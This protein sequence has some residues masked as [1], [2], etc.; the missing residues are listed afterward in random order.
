MLAATS[1]QDPLPKA[2]VP[3]AGSDGTLG[4]NIAAP[5]IHQH[6][7]PLLSGLQPSAQPLAGVTNQPVRYEAAGGDNPQT[8][9]QS[10]VKS[11]PCDTDYSQ[12]SM[13]AEQF[14]TWR[15]AQVYFGLRQWLDR[16]TGMHGHT[17][18]LYT[19]VH[20]FQRQMGKAAGMGEETLF[21]FPL[22]SI[23]YGVIIL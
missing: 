8:A 19:P 4:A 18:R 3:A 9:A 16:G 17:P 15:V 10:L 11:S 13:K 23:L 12:K 2:C 14:C 7:A 5:I 20:Q 21:F 22:P 1:R 6:L